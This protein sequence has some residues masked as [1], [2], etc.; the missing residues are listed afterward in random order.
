[1]PDRGLVVVEAPKARVRVRGRHD[2]R[3]RAVPAADIGHLASGPQFGVGTVQRRDPGLHEVGAVAGTEEPL[4][5][6]KQIGVMLMPAD[7]VAGTE[8]LHRFGKDASGGEHPLEATDHIRRAGLVGQ[9]NGLFLV[10][11]VA[12]LSGI[13][14]VPRGSHPAGP[15]PH[16][17][18]GCPGPP[19]QLGGR[20]WPGAG[21]G[22]EQAKLVADVDQRPR[23]DGTEVPHRLMHVAHQLVFVERHV[24][25]PLDARDAATGQRRWSTVQAS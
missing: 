11:F 2:D 4:G 8:G 13:V 23:Q 19:G 14:D 17:A 10:E 6:L 12:A 16:V 20:H 25:N 22:P 18:F 9:G 24:P 7:P 5:P 15:L 21:H 1:M 3:R